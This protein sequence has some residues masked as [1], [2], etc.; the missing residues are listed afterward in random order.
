MISISDLNNIP[1]IPESS[2]SLAERIIQTARAAGLED[3][4]FILL[5]EAG[6]TEEAITHELGWNPLHHPIDG[7]RHDDPSFEPYWTWIEQE[8]GWW[9][10]VVTVGT[11]FAYELLIEDAADSSFAAICRRL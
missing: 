10:V 4:T 3:E 8:Y 1:P 6:D 11:E 7:L 5:I 9:R 2:R